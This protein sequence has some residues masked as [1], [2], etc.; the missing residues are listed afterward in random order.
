MKDGLI[1]PAQVAEGLRFG[2]NPSAIEDSSQS[3][4]SQSMPTSEVIL[5]PDPL[6]TIEDMTDQLILESLRRFDDNR[7]HASQA[8]GMSRKGL[9]NRLARIMGDQ[10]GPA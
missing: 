2:E 1:H 4:T 6:P 8:I 5:F 3:F 10:N 9:I 7:T